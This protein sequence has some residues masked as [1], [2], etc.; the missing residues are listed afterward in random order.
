MAFPPAFMDMPVYKNAVR[1]H[2]I[3]PPIRISLENNLF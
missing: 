2:I 1:Y 3:S